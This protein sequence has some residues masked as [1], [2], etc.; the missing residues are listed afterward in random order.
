MRNIRVRKTWVGSQ[1]CHEQ[2]RDTRQVTLF[3]QPGFR[4]WNMRVARGPGP[5]NHSED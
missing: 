4:T 5:Q 1:L 2:L 3:L